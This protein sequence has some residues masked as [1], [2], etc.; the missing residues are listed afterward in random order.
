MLRRPLVGVLVRLSA[1]VMLAKPPPLSGIKQ[2][3]PSRVNL[4]LSISRVHR[5]L[6][7]HPRLS[8]S[9]TQATGLTYGTMIS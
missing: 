8:T 6:S 4:K 2:S 3:Q 7:F 9:P 5:S 1:H